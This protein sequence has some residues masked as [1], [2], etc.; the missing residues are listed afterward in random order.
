MAGFGNVEAV[1]LE[2]LTARLAI[3]PLVAADAAALAAITDDP[4]ITSRIDFLRAPFG[5]AEAAALIAAAAGFHGMRLR[6]GG[7]LAGM[8]GVHRQR[9]GADRGAVEIGYWV[10]TAFQ[11]R[12]YAREALAAVLAA[13]DGERVFAECHPDN[14]PS[15]SLLVALGFRPT[16]AAGRR[17][18]RAVLAYRGRA[19]G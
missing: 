12:G 6:E 1:R 13:L 7:A 17:A 9:R 2:L 8:I 3:A 4:A 15:W 18:G 14:R 10:G 5:V 19:R 16:G 11:R